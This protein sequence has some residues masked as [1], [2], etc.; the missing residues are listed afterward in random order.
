M[1]RFARNDARRFDLDAG[2]SDV[3]QWSFAVDRIAKAVD[4][5]AEQTLANRHVDNGAGALDG[6][7]LADAA[8]LAKDHDADIVALE[9]ERHALHAVRE[10]DHLAGL[11][12]VEAEDAGNAVADRQHLP[13][14]GNISLC[15]EPSNLLLQDR[16]DFRGTNFHLYPSPLSVV[17]PGLAPG[18]RERPEMAGSSPTMT[19]VKFS[20]YL[21]SRSVIAATCCAASRRSCVSRP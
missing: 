3:G 16:G 20:R 7:A 4:D 1:H 5:T 15:A 11:D 17:I 2:A 6:V 10:L 9:V 8:I 14:F 12:L 21:S 19:N 18:I 13:D